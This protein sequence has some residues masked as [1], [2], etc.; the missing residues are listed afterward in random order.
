MQAR[1]VVAL[2][3]VMLGL[4]A[5]AHAG[6]RPTPAQAKATAAAWIAA[7]SALDEDTFDYAA[8]AA[9]LGDKLHVAVDTEDPP[10]LCDLTATRE[11]EL[12]PPIGCVQKSKV[13]LSPLRFWTA[14]DLKKLSGPLHDYRQEILERS[15]TQVLLIRYERG[16][17]TVALVIIGVGLGADKRPHVSAVFVGN[18]RPA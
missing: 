18:G 13:A 12:A 7:V 11:I 16:E 17:R 9:L 2:L 4:P 6:T 10:M 1:A 3:A 5:L 14:A 8:V 15:R